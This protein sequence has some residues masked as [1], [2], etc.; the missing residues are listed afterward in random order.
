MFEELK[1]QNQ[2]PITTIGIDEATQLKII[3]ATI[4]SLVSNSNNYNDLLT[5]L[6]YL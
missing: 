5:I 2:G 6:S 3:E 4:L 1:K